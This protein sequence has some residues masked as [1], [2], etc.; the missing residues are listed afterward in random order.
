MEKQSGE[1]EQA[2]QKK[3]AFQEEVWIR[4]GDKT[5]KVRV[6]EILANYT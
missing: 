1:E 6:Q 5:Y 4:W 3:E 2:M